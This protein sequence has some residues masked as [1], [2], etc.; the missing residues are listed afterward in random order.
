MDDGHT[1]GYQR[2]EF[3]RIQYTCQVS[4][5]SVTVSSNVETSGYKPWWSSA[6]VTVFG[7]AAAPRE[8]RL[9]DQVIRDARYDNASHAVTFTVPDA[10]KNWSLQ[11]NY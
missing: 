2:N 9:G 11:L 6:E 1:F 5:N 10:V 3:L 7:A 8:I 4:G